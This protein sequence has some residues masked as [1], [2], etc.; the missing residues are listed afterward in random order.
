MI[1]NQQTDSR[2]EKERDED[3]EHVDDYVLENGD[4][5]DDVL[6]LLESEGLH[7]YIPILFVVLEAFPD[8]PDSWI[9]DELVLI[10][11]PEV[12]ADFFVGCVFVDED[13]SVEG[14]ES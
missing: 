4:L 6:P 13:V 9:G 11:E 5:D 8:A 14:E 7:F 12:P 10:G 3:Q 1:E 2:E